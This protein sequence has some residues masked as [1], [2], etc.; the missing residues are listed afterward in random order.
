MENTDD[1]PADIA[2]CQARIRELSKRVESL[3]AIANA[4]DP[5]AIIAEQQRTIDELRKQLEELQTEQD[6]LQRLL[7]K[8][9]KGNRSEKV[10]LSSS[11]QALL[12]FETPAELEE[13]QA[14]A[15]AE[16]QAML[17]DEKNRPAPKPRKRRSETLPEHLP[18]VE[19]VVELPESMMVC[20]AHGPRQVIG[21][22]ITEKLVR[23][24]AQLFVEVW[25]HPKLSCP[26][27]ATCGIVS[28][29]RPTGLVRRRS[30][31]YEH[32][33]DDHPSQV[34][35]PHAGLSSARP[36]C[37]QWLDSSTINT[38]QYRRQR[39]LRSCSAVR[40]YEAQSSIRCWCGH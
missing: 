39:M 21:Y 30:I 6:K 26:G 23:I 29:E 3:S 4:K 19:K 34:G 37:W 32:R 36:L 18:R 28:P 17:D 35:S 1:L 31:R 2:T 27:N 38:A 13:A 12:P 16:A 20:D 33:C 40:A 7:A 24:P 14:E 5:Q 9:L 25:K 22:D 11:A 8:L 10:I 15:E